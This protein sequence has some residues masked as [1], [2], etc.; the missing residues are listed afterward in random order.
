MNL[1]VV[2]GSVYERVNAFLFYI[3]TYVLNMQRKRLF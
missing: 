3:I 2:K 1:V